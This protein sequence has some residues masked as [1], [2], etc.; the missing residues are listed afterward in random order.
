MKIKSKIVFVLVL[1]S[2]ALLNSGCIGEGLTADQIA[3]KMQEKQ[4]NI[5][6]ISAT[7]HMTISIEGGTQET[8]YQLYQKNPG[9]MKNIVLMPEEMAGQTT[10][11]NGE[12]MWIYDPAANTVTIMEMPEVSDEFEMDYASIIGDLLNETD[13]SLVGTEDLDGRDTLVL[14][15]V[16]KEEDNL[17]GSGMKVWVDDET[18]TPLKIEMGTENTYQITVEYRNF[19]VNTGIS[20]DEFEFEVPDGAE[21][22]EVDDFDDILPV[23]MTLEEAQN[24]SDNEILTP[25]Y[26]PDGYELNNV[27]FSNTSIVANIDESVTLMYSYDDNGIIISE[28]FYNGEIDQKSI[29]MES[30]T[31]SVNGVEGDFYSMYGGSGMLQWEI[32]NALL[33]LSAPLEMD[34]IIQIAESME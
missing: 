6:D 4:A 12:K 2:I 30:E 34:E 16:P 11:S 9:K 23:S 10:V 25:S 20:D 26:L 33:T 14:M 21:V 5:E 13:V 3:E 8:E 28:S 32:D 18:W 19:E 31:V 1:I 17:Y 22:I 15:L 24:L 29:L 7:V 27:M